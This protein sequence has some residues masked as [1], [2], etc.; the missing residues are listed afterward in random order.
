MP[1]VEAEHVPFAIVSAEVALGHLALSLGDNEVAV[2]HFE[3]VSSMTEAMGLYEPG[4]LLWQGDYLE[5]L[6]RVGR[7]SEATQQV[8]T[9]AALGERTGQ[10]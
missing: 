1:C 7:H 4:V 3:R 2:T 9:L 10:V 5:A 8:E 6:L